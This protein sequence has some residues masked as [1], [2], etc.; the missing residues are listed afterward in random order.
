MQVRAH[1][2]LPDFQ[3]LMIALQKYCEETN[4]YVTDDLIEMGQAYACQQDDG[5][6]YRSVVFIILKIKYFC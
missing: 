2:F 4:E 1:K 3:D 5:T 6:W